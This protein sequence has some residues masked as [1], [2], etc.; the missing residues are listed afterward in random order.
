VNVRIP[1]GAFALLLIFAPVLWWPRP[2]SALIIVAWNETRG[3]VSSLADDAGFASTRSMI[4]TNF[5]GS[6]IVGV[7]TLT[8][9][10][11]TG[12]DVVWIGSATGSTTAITPLSAAEQ[13][14]MLGFVQ[15]GGTA[16][17]FGENDT[18][19]GGASPTANNSLFTSFS[20][21]NTGTLTN[22]QAYSFPS[23]SSFP[24]VGPWGTVTALSSGFPGWFDSLPAAASVVATLTANGQDVIASLPKDALDPG[25]G[26]AWFFGDTG[27]QS[28]GGV[29][30]G[31]WNTLY[32]NILS[33]V[34][35]PATLSVFAVA[36]GLLVCRRPGKTSP[37]ATSP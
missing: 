8:S 28:A 31:Q 20:A 14:A 27:S 16:V 22:T 12:A 3:G 35:E 18:F 6:S 37:R 24:L 2:A 23:P 4:A 13:S 33:G 9:A 32:A 25:S 5:P 29:Q 21:H 19:A 26:R 15:A 36:L 34:P 7:S 17:L 30:A 11:L 10:A 1:R